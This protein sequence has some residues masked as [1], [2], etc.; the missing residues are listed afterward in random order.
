MFQSVNGVYIN[1]KKI[2]PGT[3]YALQHQDLLSLGP[4]TT[5]EWR[6]E[7]KPQKVE[8]DVAETSEM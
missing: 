4:E 5:Y 1:Q 2:P 6:I 7:F 8:S 3:P